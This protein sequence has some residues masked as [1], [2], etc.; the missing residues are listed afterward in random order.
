MLGICG[1][2]QMLGTAI[3]DPHSVESDAGSVEGL[4]LLE[5]ETAL[6]KEKCLRQVS[7]FFV[8]RD[9][10]VSGYEIHMGQSYV[11]TSYSIHYTKL[12]E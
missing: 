3:H 6:Q 8:D 10:A 1:G 9:V 11:I 7:G 5:M 4:G 2:F 12:Y